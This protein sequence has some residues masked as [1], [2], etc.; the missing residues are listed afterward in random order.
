VAIYGDN[1]KDHPRWGKIRQNVVDYAGLIKGAA[2]ASTDRSSGHRHQGQH[3]H[4]DDGQERDQ[5]AE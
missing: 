1:A 3:P 4:A 2:A 5:V